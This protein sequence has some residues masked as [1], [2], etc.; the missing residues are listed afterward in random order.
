M[1]IKHD[2]VI[3]N[4]LLCAEHYHRFCEKYKSKM[5]NFLLLISK[6]SDLRMNRNSKIKWNDTPHNL[7]IKFYGL[8]LQIVKFNINSM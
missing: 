3:L 2:S 4:D 1:V 8:Y 5:K 7:N 6:K